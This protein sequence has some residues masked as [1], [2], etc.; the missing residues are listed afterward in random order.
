MKTAHDNPN[1]ARMI[2]EAPTSAPSSPSGVTIDHIAVM[3]RDLGTEIRDQ[4]TEIRTEFR[5]QGN[6]QGMEGNGG[7]NDEHSGH[8]IQCPVQQHCWHQ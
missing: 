6:D 4:E 5:V 8:Q 7:Q 2:Y 1:I 3:I